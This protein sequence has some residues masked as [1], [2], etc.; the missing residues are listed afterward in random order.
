MESLPPGWPTT[1]P[2]EAS[3]MVWLRERQKPMF[4]HE[5]RDQVRGL[6]DLVRRPGAGHRRIELG[7]RNRLHTGMTCTVGVQQGQLLGDK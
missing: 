2:L 4:G 6:P 1:A 5:A 7:G 3:F